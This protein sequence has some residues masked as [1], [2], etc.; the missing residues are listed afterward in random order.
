MMM[1]MKKTNYI[2]S[3]LILFNIDFGCLELSRSCSFA[4]RGEEKRS[5]I[6]TNR[7]KASAHKS[8]DIRSH[9]LTLTHYST[10][11]VYALLQMKMQ[12]SCAVTTD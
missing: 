6:E 8:T 2:K 10:A 3:R 5:I 12:T 9:L 7:K 4:L 1:M 11:T